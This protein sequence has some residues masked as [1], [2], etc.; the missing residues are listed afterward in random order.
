MSNFLP[1]GTVLNGKRK[2]TIESTLHSGGFGNTYLVKGIVMDENI[3]QEATYTIKEFYF[4]KYCT[5]A[6][7]GSVTVS[8]ASNASRFNAAKADFYTEANILHGLK[9]EGIVPVNEVFEQNNTV[10][11][12]MKHLGNTSLDQYVMER[13]GMLAEQEALRIIRLVAGA[14]VY[15]HNQQIL[16]LDVKPNNIMMCPGRDGKMVPVLIDFGQAMFYNNGKAKTNHVVGGYTEGYSALELKQHGADRTFVPSYDVYSLSATLFFMLTGKDPD[17]ASQISKRS[18]YLAMPSNVTERT[19]DTIVSGM[20]QNA[21]QR[22]P[23]INAF[24]AQLSGSAN[25]GNA[26][27]MQGMNGGRVTD[28][29]IDDDNTDHSKMIR[30]A[31]IAVAV[32]VVI[33]LVVMAVGKLGNGGQQPSPSNPTVAQNDST[34]ADTAHIYNK[35]SA[36]ANADNVKTDEQKAGAK[37]TVEPTTADKQPKK[38]SAK[39]PS[40]S[41]ADASTAS[42]PTNGTVNLGYATWTGGLRAGKPHGN[43]TMRFRS[44]HSISGCS[45][46]AQS[47][48]YVVGFCE[49]GVLQS[50]ALY[51]DGEK[52]ETFVR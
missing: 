51:H 30:L 4:A 14:L 3:A 45:T 28:P 39:K 26:A 7:D 20:A 15:L 9:H 19:I 21:Q 23:S 24:L 33:V 48:D 18:V 25:A 47:G 35:V 37:P 42:M 17:D 13:G 11:Y 43:G 2:Y 50:G 49:N 5:R 31:G 46:T 29:T 32:V 36:D 38:E 8:D 6:A 12:V 40:T 1:V 41:S 16:H 27:G 44:S 22:T 52:V 34:L 10:Y